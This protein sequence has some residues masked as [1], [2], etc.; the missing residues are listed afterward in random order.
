MKT[1][2]AFRVGQTAELTTIFTGEKVVQFA[3]I[4]NDH[5]P[6]HLDS[7]YAGK[8]RFGKRIV[9]GFLVGSLIS[10]V[11]ANIMRGVG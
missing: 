1:I 7:E 8:S 2:Q 11:I 9:H 5:N 6:I 3:D 10:A 4:S